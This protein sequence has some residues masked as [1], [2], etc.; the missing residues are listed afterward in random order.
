MRKLGLDSATIKFVIMSHAH[1]DY[2]VSA[3]LMQDRFGLR[4]TRVPANWP[5]MVLKRD[6]VLKQRGR[7]SRLSRALPQPM[8]PKVFQ[9]SVS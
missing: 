9:L 2:A 5:G 7:F 8:C 6:G 1:G 4:V 3:K